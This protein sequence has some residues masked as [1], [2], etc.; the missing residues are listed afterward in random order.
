MQ[1]SYERFQPSRGTCILS[2]AEAVKTCPT[3][4]ASM[5]RAM[6]VCSLPREALRLCTAT[7]FILS[8]TAYTTQCL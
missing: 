7:R 6:L 8:S 4:S 3:F 1:Q 5:F 2:L